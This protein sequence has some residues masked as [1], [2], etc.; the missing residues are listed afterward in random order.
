MAYQQDRAAKQQIEMLK[1][2]M[3]GAATGLT[4]IWQVG[5]APR[6]GTY[7][8]PFAVMV[9]AQNSEIASQMAL[10]KYPGY[11]LV[12]VRKANR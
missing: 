1:L 9:T 8:R 3:L 6:Q 5:L 4:S 10:Q 7:G 2:E 12:G 11:E